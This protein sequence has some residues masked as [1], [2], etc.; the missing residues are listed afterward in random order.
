M[1]RNPFA[2]TCLAALSLT[3]AAHAEIDHVVLETP[4]VVQ[5][6]F[7]QNLEI[8][9]LPLF[10]PEDPAN[11]GQTPPFDVFVNHFFAPDFTTFQG[12]SVRAFPG[13]VVLTGEAIDVTYFP[14]TPSETTLT[15]QA[16]ANLAPGS[17]ISRL[18]IGATGDATQDFLGVLAVRGE[19]FGDFYVPDGQSI[20]GM[21]GLSF[22]GL[23]TPFSERENRRI[24][25]AW[26]EFEIVAP[27]AG[28]GLGTF[29][30]TQW[31][32]ETEYDKPI[33]AGETTNSVID[34][35]ANLDGTVDLIDL[36]A[37]A[38]N[39]GT[40]NGRFWDQGDF[41][42]DGTVDLIDLSL[43]ATN[44]GTTTVPEPASAALLTLSM[45]ALTRRTK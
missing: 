17:P 21:V 44:F 43:L 18:N 19:Q 34:G 42:L 10:D 29:T 37:L 41:N 45:L 26:V 6:G 40:S 8:D 15:H 22:V 1:S 31:A 5:P 35:D 2:I 4:I 11:A 30:I 36:S 14:G 32:Y 27:P 20:T 28:N 24:N 23:D 9:G 13:S 7:T 39:F 12:I 16:L 3:A 38:T 33:L 25:Y